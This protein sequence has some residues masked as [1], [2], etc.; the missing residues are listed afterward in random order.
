[1]FDD[2]ELGDNL[3]ALEELA[4]MGYIDRDT[5]AYGIAKKYLHEGEASLSE[6]QKYV[7]NKEIAPVIFKSCSRCSE[8]IE[9]SALPIAYEEDLMLCSYH[10]HK[11]YKDE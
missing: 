6:K 5:A 3:Q 8:G 1:M 2:P 4:D 7:F 11:H 9:L 10:R